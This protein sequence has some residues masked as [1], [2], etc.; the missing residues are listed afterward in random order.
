MDLTSRISVVISATTAGAVKELD[1][2]HRSAA[3]SGDAFDSIGARAGLAGSTIKAGLVAGATALVGTGLVSFLNDSVT[4]FGDA[5]KAAGDLASASGGTVEGVSRMQAALADAGVSSETSADL[6]T[7]FTTNAGKSK[8][9][10]DDL[11]VVLKKNKD[12]SID[13]ANGMVQAVD[14]ILKIGD[15]SERNQKFVELFGKKGAKA[16]QDLAASGVDLSAAMEAVSKYRVF[17]DA[18][19]ASAARYDDAM[20]TLGASV[21]GLQFSLG[22]AL[23]P[24][25]SDTAG[26][27]AGVVSAATPVLTFFAELPPSLYLTVGAVVALNQ[28]MKS[29]AIMAAV[30]GLVVGAGRLAVGVGAAVTQ[31]GVF[32]AAS[33]VFTTGAA[34]V[35]GALVS[36]SATAGPLIAVAAAID[37]VMA[38]ANRNPTLDDFATSAGAVGKS[39]REMGKDAPDT[40]STVQKLLDG[41]ANAGMDRATKDAIEL[42]DRI[43]KL[44]ISRQESAEATLADADA[45]D[46]QKAAAQKLLDVI[47]EGDA[48][49]KSQRLNTEE[50]TEALKA[51]AEATGGAQGAALLLQ[52]AQNELSDITLDLVQNGAQAASTWTDVA[53]AAGEANIRT[54]EQQQAANLAEVAMGQYAVSLQGVADW[55]G[56][57]AE[58]AANTESALGSL[59][60]TLGQVGK[61]LDDP[62]TWE[63]EI[64]LNTAKAEADLWKYV[65]LLADSGLTSEQII[66]LLMELQ[67]KEE[68]GAEADAL[69]QAVIAAVQG[70]SNEMPVDIRTKLDPASAGSTKAGIDGLVVPQQAPLT[71]VTTWADGGYGANKARKDYMAQAVNATLTVLPVFADGGYSANKDRKDYLA[72]T[73]TG[74]VFI[75]TV[76]TDGGYSANK[77]RKDYLSQDTTAT[78]TVNQRRGVQIPGGADGD[79]GTPW[80]L[81]VPTVSSSVNPI[82]LVRVLLDG[83]QLR[84]VVRD[85]IRAGSPVRQGVA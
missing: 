15:A 81:P 83:Q 5:A 59:Q 28:A 62:A 9:T 35:G 43:S 56:K 61:V 63:N 11:G 80:R 64:V 10:L 54:L 8:D 49:T 46:T 32:G 7:K 16:F 33:S 39:I 24:I 38:A 26:A 14:A 22:E 47:G 3:K 51:Y 19:V 29:Q 21:Q 84:A 77:A 4:K 23:I 79:P 50:G 72:Q 73:V 52:Q 20:D 71:V 65:G 53:A 2:L 17:T 66:P 85:E 69:I 40:R 25:L 57:V 58:S 74:T 30:D 34:A 1:D 12:G 75:N 67:G 37:E 6:L 78:I 70:K 48:V 27:M 13:Y 55:Q 44:T 31:M 45:T 68:T 82:N 36:L 42:Q 60:D 18:D 41:I 76:F